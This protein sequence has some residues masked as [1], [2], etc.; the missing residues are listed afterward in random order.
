[1]P[2]L[3]SPDDACISVDVPTYGGKARYNGRSVDVSNASHVKALRQV[4]YTVADTSGA[5]VRRGGYHC[6][7]CGFASYFRLCS[8]CGAECKRPDLAA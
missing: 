1:M 5:P 8:R 3:L 6:G 7:P 4:G 2:R